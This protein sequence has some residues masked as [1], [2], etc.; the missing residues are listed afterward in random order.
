[1]NDFPKLIIYDSK[2]LT[3]S[4]LLEQHLW[5]FINK[6]N[7]VGFY[8]HPNSN[9][10]QNYKFQTSATTNSWNSVVTQ[11]DR[12]LKTFCLCFLRCCVNTDRLLC[13]LS[14]P[15][16]PA[17]KLEIWEDLKIISKPSGVTL[18]FFTWLFFAVCP[19]TV[20][21]PSSGFTRTIVGVYSTCMLVVLLRVQL[22]IIGG[23]LYLDNS[24]GRNM[25]VGG[26]ALGRQ[27]QPPEAV[28]DI[29]DVPLIHQWRD[30]HK[31]LFVA[32]E[33]VIKGHISCSDFSKR[34]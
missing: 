6:Q 14:L 8:R 34:L 21:I 27:T 32:M 33:T 9:R 28:I 13:L 16:R 31:K 1:M 24:A 30:Q 26:A 25:E 17:N 18:L 12:E 29:L 7:V 15:H 23:Y 4:P 20:R 5:S 2:V 10:E 19:L 11:F 22:N 3:A